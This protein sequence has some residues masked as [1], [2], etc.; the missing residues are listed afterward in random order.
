[1]KKKI[2]NKQE[3]SQKI[4][5]FILE[6]AISLWLKNVKKNVYDL[7]FDNFKHVLNLQ[8]S[9]LHVRVNIAKRSIIFFK[10]NGKETKDCP[11]MLLHLLWEKIF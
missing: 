1:M 5:C 2:Q 10:F 3:V 11:S 9:S 7:K 8:V 4:I 6:T